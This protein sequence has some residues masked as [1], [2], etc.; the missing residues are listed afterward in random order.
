MNNVELSVLL[1]FTFKTEMKIPS[2]SIQ[3]NTEYF[4][5]NFFPCLKWFSTNVLEMWSDILQFLFVNILR[6]PFLQKK[7]V[8]KITDR[9]FT[10][11]MLILL[12]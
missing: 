8:N 1:K 12:Q 6:S 7:I 3:I 5:I 10:K 4:L 9:Y 2:I 11:K